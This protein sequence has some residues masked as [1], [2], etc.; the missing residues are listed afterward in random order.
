[1]GMTENSLAGRSASR[2][3]EDFPMAA[4]ME[5]PAPSSIQP[6]SFSTFL[7]HPTPRAHAYS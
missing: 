7:R 1:M 4:Y 3:D 6:I 5:L 2:R